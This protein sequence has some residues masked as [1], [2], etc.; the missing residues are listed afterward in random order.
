M[1]D[2]SDDKVVSL[3][4]VTK[5]YGAAPVLH[6]VSLTMQPGELTAIV[7]RSGSGKTTLLHIIGGLDRQ[8]SGAARVF[9]IDLAALSD[10][11]LARFRNERVGFVFQSF[12]L[13]E[14]LSCVENVMLPAYF[15]HDPEGESHSRVMARA[16]EALERVGIADKATAL[17]AHLSGGQKQRVAIARALFRKPALLLADEPTGNLDSHTGRQIIELF[18]D[19]NREGLTLLIVT[20]E[21][22]ISQAA[23]RVIRLEDGR[24]VDTNSNGGAA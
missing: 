15:A 20:H 3:N 9:G 2:A 18:Q 24:V 10:S 4:G 11:K 5:Y 14:H 21:E 7:G 23:R 6:D 8:F 19:L 13:L 22:R 1:N 16:R 17:P 12:N